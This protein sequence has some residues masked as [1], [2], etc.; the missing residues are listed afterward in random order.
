M[1][2]GVP[3][4]LISNHWAEISLLFSVSFAASFCSDIPIHF[5]KGSNAISF[6]VLVL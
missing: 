3:V 5:L 6:A 4:R 2:G 1:S